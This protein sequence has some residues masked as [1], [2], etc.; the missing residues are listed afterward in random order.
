MRNLLTP[1]AAL[2]ALLASPAAMA[3]WDIQLQHE[4]NWNEHGQHSG[5]IEPRIL[6]KGQDWKIQLEIEKQVQPVSRKAAL[7]FEGQYNWKIGQNGSLGLNTE[8]VY[9]QESKNWAGELT[10]ELYWNLGDGFEIGFEL[11]IDYLSADRW[12]L[13]EIEIE[14][15]VSWEGPLG[16]GYLYLELEAPVMRLYSAD[17]SRKDVEFETVEPIVGYGIQLTPATDLYMELASPY[18]VQ[19]RSWSTCFDIGVTHRF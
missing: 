17:D 14:P 9:D 18:D 4:S 2:P 11:E 12:D 15:T 1:L 13:H 8:V 5:A 7:E 3:G 19:D 16:P 10:P 6:Y